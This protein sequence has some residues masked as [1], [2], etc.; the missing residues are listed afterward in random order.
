MFGTGAEAAAKAAVGEGGRY[1]DGEGAEVCGDAARGEDLVAK[2]PRGEQPLPPLPRP[3]P[4][5]DDN[6]PG[7][8]D[9]WLPP[10]TAVATE[11]GPKPPRAPRIMILE[12][13]C[14]A[15]T[16]CAVRYQVETHTRCLSQNGCGLMLLVMMV[17]VVMVMMISDYDSN[18]ML[19]MVL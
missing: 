3:V 11:R 12:T 15:K 5:A 18:I 16:D 13:H 14:V 7:G 4:P 17:I 2:T 19:Q 1:P 10:Y 8:P 6:M 9:D